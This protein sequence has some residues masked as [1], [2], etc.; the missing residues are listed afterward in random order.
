LF[1]LGVGHGISRDE[2]CALLRVLGFDITTDGAALKKD[3]PVI[4]LVAD[5]EIWRDDGSKETRTM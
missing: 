3:E 1:K 4:I 5:Q 2:R